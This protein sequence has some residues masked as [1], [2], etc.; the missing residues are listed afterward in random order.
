VHEDLDRPQSDGK[1]R[2]QPCPCNCTGTKQ[3]A[4]DVTV[5]KLNSTVSN[6][7]WLDING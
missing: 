1:D 2:S 7:L 6:A 5:E 4:E 3:L